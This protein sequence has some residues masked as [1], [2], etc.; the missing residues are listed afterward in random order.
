MSR[1]GRNANFCW[2]YKG[3]RGRGHSTCAPA[4]AVKPRR[5]RLSGAGP[6]GLR[7][8]TSS[9]AQAG[10]RRARRYARRA[11]RG[12]G[13][14]RRSWRESAGQ[15]LYAARVCPADRREAHALQLVCHKLLPNT[16]FCISPQKGAVSSSRRRGGQI[17]GR[18]PDSAAQD[19]GFTKSAK[20]ERFI[21][22]ISAILWIRPVA[23]RRGRTGDAVEARRPL[24]EQT[25]SNKTDGYETRARAGPGV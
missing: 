25:R 5:L 2:V 18:F 21:W 8:P 22:N 11:R 19:R 15:A 4:G 3:S 7:A 10:W 20:S 17:R 24:D 16:G 9:G 23:D 14:C 13:W 1:V 6:W 12:D